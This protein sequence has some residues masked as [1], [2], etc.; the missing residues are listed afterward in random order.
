MQIELVW[1]TLKICLMSIFGKYKYILSTGLFLIVIIIFLVLVLMGIGKVYKG[2]LADYDNQTPIDTL[3]LIEKPTI[4]RI[5]FQKI[6]SEE[7]IEVMPD[8][9]VRV[10]KTCDGDLESFQRASNPR[11]ILDLYRLISEQDWSD[12]DTRGEGEYLELTIE[13]DK[14]IATLYIP[15]GGGNAS[16]D[17]ILDT[18]DEVIENIPPNPT[19]SPAPS[20]GNNN[21]SPSPITS[22]RS[23]PSPSLSSS[24]S[25]YPQ[26]G[27]DQG[28]ACDFYDKTSNKKPYRVS[29]VVC[30]G[31][32]SPLP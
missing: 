6:G 28:F 12:F 16:A 14:G 1:I 10:Y 8:G 32:P 9:S 4:K 15:A 13:T 18:I 20:T 21:P 22:P 25:P 19:P 7:C 23:L 24:E 31:E 2:R 3:E 27:G 29:N 17:I 5:R 30:T 11:S 26:T